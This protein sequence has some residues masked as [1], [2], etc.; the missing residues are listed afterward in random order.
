MTI[1]HEHELRELGE[2]AAEVAQLIAQPDWPLG[3]FQ[4]IVRRELKPHG[5]DKDL[6]SVEAAL[7]N[8]AYTIEA[9]LQNRTR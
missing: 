5:P 4:T 2:R 1:Q 3:V 9:Y 6:Q 7:V 8:V